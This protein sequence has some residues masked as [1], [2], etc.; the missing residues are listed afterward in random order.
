MIIIK[1]NNKGNKY[2]I[3]RNKKKFHFDKLNTERFYFSISKQN[4][5]DPTTALNLCNRYNI[6]ILLV[7]WYNRRDGD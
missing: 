7:C 1:S 6:P 4:L 2:K 5:N 3:I